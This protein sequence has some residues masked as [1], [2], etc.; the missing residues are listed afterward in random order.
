MCYCEMG[1]T[2]ERCELCAN[3]YF[4][5]P[6]VLGGSC[7]MCNCHGNFDPN[8]VLETCDS[9]TGKNINST[10]PNKNLLLLN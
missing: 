10:Y 8:M 2:G 4:G 9:F 5:N 1:Y 3:G 7:K 6:A